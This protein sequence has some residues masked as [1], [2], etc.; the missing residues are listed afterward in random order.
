MKLIRVGLVAVGICAATL[1][2]NAAG[3][4]GNLPIV[5]S[6]AYCALFA[7]DGVTCQGNVPAGP[8]VLTGTEKIA[9]DT[10]L[11]SGQ[12]PQTVL[13]PLAAIGAL[14]YQFAAPLTGATVAVAATTGT[15]VLDPA[16]TIA[17]LTVT[18]PAA[19][20][21][22]DGQ[23]FAISSSQ[24]VTA[25]TLTAGSGTTISNTPTAITIST[26][27]SYGYKFVYRAANTKWYRVT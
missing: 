8:S 21:L 2:A 27:A 15:L 13:V 11:A 5:G 24:T 14:P 20:S 7:G 9:A 23:T 25:L 26:T 16:G 22:I 6:A 17:T 19:A 1:T 12:S 10:G 3:M 18:L 4:F